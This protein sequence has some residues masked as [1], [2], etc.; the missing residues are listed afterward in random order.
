[1]ERYLEKKSEE[2]RLRLM[3]ELELFEAE[4][5]RRIEEARRETLKIDE[6]V[7][8]IKEA[9]LYSLQMVLSIQR[10]VQ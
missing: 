4:V 10:R 6:R 1:V 2:N 8:K 5:K 9:Q 7:E 3:G